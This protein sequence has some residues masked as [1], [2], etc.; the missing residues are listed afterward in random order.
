MCRME[1]EFLIAFYHHLNNCQVCK[2]CSVLLVTNPF[3]PADVR[4]CFQHKCFSECSNFFSLIAY[5]HLELHK[6][7][8]S[9][10]L[11]EDSG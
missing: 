3:N 10:V 8:F 9:S 6:L 4:S 11:V 5:M 7:T 1:V 2:E